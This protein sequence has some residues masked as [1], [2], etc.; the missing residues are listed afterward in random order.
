LVRRSF[1]SYGNRRRKKRGDSVRGKSRKKLVLV[2][3]PPSEIS[4][5][6]PSEKFGFRISSRNRWFRAGL[7]QKPVLLQRFPFRVVDDFGD[8]YPG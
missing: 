4:A 6:A 1:N 8:S 3:Q 7:F 2:T 5:K